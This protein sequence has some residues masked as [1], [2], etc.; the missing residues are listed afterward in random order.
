MSMLNTSSSWNVGRASGRCAT[1]GA[2]LTVDKPCWAALCD[3]L[4]ARRRA[5]SG[6]AEKGKK[7]AAVEAPSP[8]VRIDFCE[9]CWNQGKR[10]EQLSPAA[11]GLAEEGQNAKLAMFSFWKTTMPLPQQ[12]KK[13]LV[14]DSVLMDVFQ[15][16]EG[17]N[18]P[19]EVRFRFVL[20]LI[21]MRKRLLKYEGT[22]AQEAAPVE[23]PPVG[24]APEAE[25]GGT[26]EAGAPAASPSLPAVPPEVWRMLPKSMEPGGG[27]GVAVDVVN[28]H[29][30]EQQ[31]TEVSQQLSA[32]LAEEV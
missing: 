18:E 12:K 8:F 30:T 20:A 5:E 7:G 32:I 22:I 11:L 2:E 31:I 24:V 16:M 4:P 27:W 25:A 9:G 28:P 1:C 17:K 13:L 10:P 26:G 19:Q 21:L 15:R 23:A 29:L 14:D 6:P 3:G